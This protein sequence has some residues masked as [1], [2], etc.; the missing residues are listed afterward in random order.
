MAWGAKEDLIIEMR[1]QSQ[2]LDVDISVRASC[3]DQL[4][5]TFQKL[6]TNLGSSVYP[7]K[8]GPRVALKHS[9]KAAPIRMDDNG[10][11]LRFLRETLMKNAI[12]IVSAKNLDLI[13]SVANDKVWKFVAQFP[14]DLAREIDAAM[15]EQREEYASLAKAVRATHEFY[16][17]KRRVQG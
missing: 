11:T 15:E 17:G 9:F 13:S 16:R 8:R 4:I 2:S 5:P 14:S 10:T 6:F 1:T 7:F 12:H 3:A